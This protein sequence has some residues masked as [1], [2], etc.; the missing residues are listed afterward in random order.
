MIYCFD[1][2]GT[3]CS[4]TDGDYSKAVPFHEVIAEVNRLFA[5]G[6]RILLYTARGAT[7]GFDWY[8]LTGRQLKEW[9]VHYHALFMGKPTADVYI[10]DKA[11]NLIDWKRNGFHVNVPSLADGGGE[12]RHG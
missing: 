6:H 1:I 4:N 11:M 7:T 8:E 9:E 5:E 2:D 12:R 10:D 3:L